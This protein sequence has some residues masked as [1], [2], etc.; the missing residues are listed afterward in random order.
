MRVARVTCNGV[1]VGCRSHQAREML[2]VLEG[3]RAGERGCERCLGRVEVDE[4]RT[5]DAET[6][7]VTRRVE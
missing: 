6:G 4:E 2:Q 7:E 5:V 3:R 1:S